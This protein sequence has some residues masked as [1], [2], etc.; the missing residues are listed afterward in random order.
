MAEKSRLGEIETVQE[1]VAA[2]G[3]IYGGSFF[4][5][6]CVLT[7]KLLDSEYLFGRFFRLRLFLFCN[8][9]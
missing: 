6:S 8:L 7:G 1:F 3:Q 9:Q 4:I 5:R 2:I